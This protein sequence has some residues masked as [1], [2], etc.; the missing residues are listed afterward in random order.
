MCSEGSDVTALLERIRQGSPQAKNDLVAVLYDRFRRRAHQRLRNERPGNSFG[1]MDLANEALLRLLQND[2]FARASNRHWMYRAF[3]RALRQVLIDHA[4]RRHADKR[5][6]DRQREE[7]DDLAES[8][9]AKS[10]TDVLSLAEALD[11]LAAEYPREA[12]VLPMRFFGGCEM[13]EI[14]EALGVSL[15]TVE[16]ES[17]FGQAWLREFLAAEGGS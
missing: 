13:A 16:R 8:V 15:S 9:Q 6:G 7:M 17:R 12:E 10:Q 2:E 1:T 11:A 4:R 3:A 5:G 14:A